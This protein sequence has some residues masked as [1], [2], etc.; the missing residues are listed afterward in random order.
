[1]G[2]PLYAIRCFFLAAFNIFSLCLIFDSFIIMCLGMFL[3]GFQ[4]SCLLSVPR[5]HHDPS[6]YQGLYKSISFSQEC[7]SS[8]T[9]LRYNWSKFETQ[10]L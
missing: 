3:P 1:M 9:F 5:I 8:V 7:L 6:R 2:F 4:T 10:F